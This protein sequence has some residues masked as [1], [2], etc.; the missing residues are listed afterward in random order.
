VPN[1]RAQPTAEAG[2]RS[3]EGLGLSLR[4]GNFVVSEAKVCKRNAVLGRRAPECEEHAHVGQAALH[5][6]LGIGVGHC[7]QTRLDF[8]LPHF[9]TRH[10][11]TTEPFR[12][13]ATLEHFVD[14]YRKA[15]LPE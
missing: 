13:A 7:R 9:A 5:D 3:S 8:L 1:A 14:G 12:D 2:R 11:A 6:L 10:C 15:G 4:V